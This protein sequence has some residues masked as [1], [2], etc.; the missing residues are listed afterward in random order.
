M[1]IPVLGVFSGAWILN[2]VLHWQDWVATGLM[3]LAIVSVLW[4]QRAQTSSEADQT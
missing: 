4:P 3:V 1:M 2:E